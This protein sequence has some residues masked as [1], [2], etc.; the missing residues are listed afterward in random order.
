MPNEATLSAE[1]FESAY[2]SINCLDYSTPTSID[3]PLS[4]ISDYYFES[5]VELVVPS[6]EN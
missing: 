3:N 1:D 2:P 6:I 5:G 4:Q